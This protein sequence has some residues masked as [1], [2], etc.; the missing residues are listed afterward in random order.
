MK[1]KF[2]GI[3]SLA[4][5]WL[6]AT[7]LCPG[8]Q[9]GSITTSI[10]TDDDEPMERCDQIKVRFGDW[11]DPMPMARS[12]QQLKVSRSE[13]APLILKLSEGAGMRIQSWDKDEYSIV[14]CK[15]AGGR[16]SEKAQHALDTIAV[17]MQGGRLSA[18]GPEAGNWLI[19][20]LVKAPKNAQMELE[21]E[22]GEIGLWEV[23]G[24][25]RARSENGPIELTRCSQEI[26]ATTQ[27]GPISLSGGSGDFR[28]KA[29]NGPISVDL[30]GG[31]WKGAGL[32]ARTENGPLSLKLPGNYKTGIR[33]EASGNSPMSCKA[34]ECREAHKSWED[35][36][37]WIE[38]NGTPRLVK[39]YTVNGPVSV[40][41]RTVEF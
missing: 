10:T 23:S 33:V 19:Y 6:L 12:E 37:R 39:L 7:V 16:T 34:A 26:R 14:V 18:R 25:V 28:L 21:T 38:F 27:N 11:S 5:V 41:S 17:S 32:E 8:V 13:A 29:E 2:T 15:V 9:A 3:L 35:D 20:L 30:S 1:H 36:L 22:S 31:G 24:S 40:E 4:S